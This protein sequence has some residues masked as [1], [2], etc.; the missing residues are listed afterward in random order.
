MN[1]RIATSFLWILFFN[2]L[3]IGTTQAAYFTITPKGTLPTSVPLNVETVAEY[4]VENTSGGPSA[5]GTTLAWADEKNTKFISQETEGAGVCDAQFSQLQP[6]N[7]S[8][9]LELK[10]LVNDTSVVNQFV[11]GVPKICDRLHPSFCSDPTSTEPLNAKIMP[12]LS[13]VMHVSSTSLTVVSDSSVDLTVT[14]TGTPGSELK[15]VQFVNAPNLNMEY[16]NCTSVGKDEKCTI[17]VKLGETASLS[18]V[19]LDLTADDVAPVP[20]Q[21]QLFPQTATEE[22]DPQFAHVQYKSI[23]FTNHSASPVQV[24]KI[25]FNIWSPHFFLCDQGKNAKIEC[26]NFTRST[27]RLSQSCLQA[28]SS[29]LLHKEESC[30]IWLKT[31][32]VLSGD[33]FTNEN[34]PPSKKEIK[35]NIELTNPSAPDVIYPLPLTVSLLRHVG[36]YLGGNF[37]LAGEVPHTSR[38]AYFDGLKF[39]PVGNGIDSKLDNGDTQINALQMF[40]GDLYAGGK[41]NKIGDTPVVSANNVSYWNGNQWNILTTGDNNGTTSPVNVLKAWQVNLFDKSSERLGLGFDWGTVIDVNAFTMLAVWDGQNWSEILNPYFDAH[42]INWCPYSRNEPRWRVSSLAAVRGT[43]K[44]QY[45]M[46]GGSFCI[47]PGTPLR[48]KIASRA[49]GLRRIDNINTQGWW[50]WRYGAD[51]TGIYGWSDLTN[52]A[53]IYTLVDKI[54]GYSGAPTG[55][56]DNTHEISRP[57]FQQNAPNIYAL[58]SLKMNDASD[59]QSLLIGGDQD[60]WVAVPKSHH[61]QD[62]KLLGLQ[63]DRPRTAFQYSIPGTNQLVSVLEPW[64]AGE[65]TQIRAF[66]SGLYTLSTTTS[67]YMAG[68]SLP[69]GAY[70]AK[71]T[72]DKGELAWSTIQDGWKYSDERKEDIV[73]SLANLA[74]T[75]YVGGRFTDAGDSAKG[76]NNIAVLDPKS[77]T[78]LPLKTRTGTGVTRKPENTAR[79]NALLPATS[80]T[81]GEVQ[82]G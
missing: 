68:R 45:M 3:L 22:K 48:D 55:M 35:F 53:T 49:F 79:V 43:D 25:N 8:C 40:N 50:G 80:L 7:G 36:L 73:L 10:I 33:R 14:N 56:P 41:F 21:F 16:K 20:I 18:K 13:P 28:E 30:Y 71:G 9:T 4:T 78:L 72:F 77:N 17:T 39:Y 57:R 60:L 5:G 2:F 70:I 26:A 69:K 29:L 6:V 64:A 19:T 76:I 61:R 67:F 47:N 52:D 74:D 63:E 62:R 1:N 23:K 82:L 81:I 44:Q 42:P 66:A 75:L 31:S 11:H 34:A 12:P 38:I 59:Q 15:N 37:D 27:K 32:D 58:Y 54:A 51:N 65:N 24:K 46:A